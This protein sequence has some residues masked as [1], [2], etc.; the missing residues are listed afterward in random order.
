MVL[1]ICQLFG[2][3]NKFG[4]VWMIT[5]DLADVCRDYGLAYI[6]V[7]VK[8][9]LN[10]IYII[11]PIVALVGLTY[12]LIRLMANPDSK[13]AKP[14]IKNWILAF[15]MFFLVPMLINLVMGLFDGKFQFA[16]CWNN[17]EELYGTISGPSSD[18]DDT[19]DRKP[20]KL[21]DYSTI[22]GNSSTSND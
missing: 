3:S 19:D 22:E 17:A 4:G 18:Y 11:G 10:V 15:F 13:K 21:D 5:G 1:G 2:L 14:A 16:T 8:K 20:G 12:H 7:I 6:L 9:F